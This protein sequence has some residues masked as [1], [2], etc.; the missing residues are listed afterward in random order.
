MKILKQAC[1]NIRV[2]LISK[3]DYSTR[4]KRPLNSKLFK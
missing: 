4:A 3:S 1:I 2:N